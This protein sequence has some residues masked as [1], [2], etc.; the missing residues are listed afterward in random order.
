MIKKHRD[1][2]V[3]NFNDKM[4]YME[5]C[6]MCAEGNCTEHSYNVTKGPDRYGRSYYND[7]DFTGDEAPKRVINKG[8]KGRPKKADSEKSAANLPTFGKK[9]NDPFGRVPGEPPKGKKGT[10]HTM[11]ES[12]SIL[13][14]KLGRIVESVNFAEMMRDHDMT[15]E[16]M[17]NELHADMDHYKQTGECSDKLNAFL[18][19]HNHS[20]KQLADEAA[21]QAADPWQHVDM[22]F[23]QG[24]VV[25]HR[26]QQGIVD[27]C[28]GNKCFVH[29]NNGDMA[30]W[31]TLELGKEKQGRLDVFK[32][33]VGDI[34]KGLK[35]FFTGGEEPS[36]TFEDQE[37]NEL[38]RLAGL[39]VVEGMEEGNAFTAKLKDTPKGEKFD[40]DGKEYTDTSEL[41]EEP[42]MEGNA[43][44]K[45]VRDAKK[46]GVQPGETVTVGGKEIAVKDANELIQMMKIAGLDS[47]KLEEALAK[48]TATY[49]STDVEDAGADPVNKPKPKYQSMKGSTMNPGEGDFGEK[50]NYDGLGD[51]K[52][53]PQPDRPAKPVKQIPT[54]ESYMEAEYESIKKSVK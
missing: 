29:L 38:A 23:N 25:F 52:M 24:D 14:K 39:D 35:G 40:L 50:D 6:A 31:P 8:V 51:N 12:L 28:E 21:T 32:K 54:L 1:A 45:A 17:L 5:E 41:D 18:K 27:R 10:V 47:S 2:D 48:T 49:G 42:E 36:N 4:D 11:G 30:V 3:K 19:V 44:G 16:E 9:F 37:L 13:E 7:P 15:L 43:F 46:D 22:G 34:G 26:G 20:K 33:D 53:K